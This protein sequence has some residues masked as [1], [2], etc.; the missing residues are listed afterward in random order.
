MMSFI[1]V[2]SGAPPATSSSHKLAFAFGASIGG[3]RF[4]A[5]LSMA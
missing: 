3:S 1:F 4:S 5:T 2:G